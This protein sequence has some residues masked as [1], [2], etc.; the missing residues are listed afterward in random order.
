MQE[1]LNKAM[2]SLSETIGE[3]VP[4]FE[5]VREKVES[6]YA[7]AKVRPSSTRTRSRVACSRS[8]RRR[9]TSRPAP[10]SARSGPSSGSTPR[11]PSRPP[12]RP[13]PRRPR[14]KATARPR[15]PWG[16]LP[17][18][19]RRRLPARHRSRTHPRSRWRL[20]PTGSGE[21]RC[22]FR[23]PP[24]PIPRTGRPP[25]EVVSHDAVSGIHHHQ[26]VGPT[27]GWAGEQAARAGQR[28]SRTRSSRWITAS[29]RCSGSEPVWRPLWASTSALDQAT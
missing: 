6:R 29:G 16:T 27:G 19:A 4:S 11:P 22:R 3:E 2:S 17:H 13:R 7:K 23:H 26:I 8:S 12:P 28:G 14:P 5:E 9:S 18:A 20:H 24:P 25:Q 15:D 1:Q 10:D 21:P